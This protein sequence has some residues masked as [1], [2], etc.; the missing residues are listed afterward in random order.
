[1][2]ISMVQGPN[3]TFSVLEHQYGICY[4]SQDMDLCVTFH[5]YREKGIL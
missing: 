1:M 3:L 2:K 5:S 4:L